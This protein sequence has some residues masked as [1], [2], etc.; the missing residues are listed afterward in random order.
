MPYHLRILATFHGFDKDG[1]TVDF[2]H[3]HDVFVAS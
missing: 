2:D 3:H 1:I